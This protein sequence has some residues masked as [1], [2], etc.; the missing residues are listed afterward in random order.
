[1]RP[2][3]AKPQGQY[4]RSMRN[5]DLSFECTETSYPEFFHLEHISMPPLKPLPLPSTKIFAQFH[6]THMVHKLISLQIQFHF[7]AVQVV[8]SIL[9]QL[10]SQTIFSSKLTIDYQFEA[11]FFW[12]VN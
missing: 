4:G 10:G 2:Q 7:F 1:M 5:R 12:V 3:A 11:Y 9:I 8:Y 6:S